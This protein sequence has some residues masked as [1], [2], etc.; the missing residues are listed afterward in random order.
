MYQHHKS[1]DTAQIANVRVRAICRLESLGPF[2]TLAANE[3]VELPAQRDGESSRVAYFGAALGSLE[4][5]VVTRTKLDGVARPGPMIVE[6]LD[7]TTVI[8]PGVTAKLD[9]QC[10]LVIELS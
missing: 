7:S 5:P 10:N 2:E 4:T 1:R 3:R 6:E 9:E 8:P